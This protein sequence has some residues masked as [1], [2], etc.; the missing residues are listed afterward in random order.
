MKINLWPTQHAHSL[1]C[2][3]VFAFG[4]ALYFGLPLEPSFFILLG[5]NLCVLGLMF[6]KP[7]FFLKLAFFFCLGLT[8]ASARTHLVHTQ[9]LRV[10]LWN[11]TITGQVAQA[12]TT[13]TGQK[14]I[15]KNIHLK[16]AVFVPNTIRL[17]FKE[18][19]PEL[20]A[21]DI[22]SF[23]GHLTPPSAHQ[24]LRF[25]YQG[26]EAQGTISKIVSFHP[27]P[28]PFLDDMRH[29]IMHRLQHHLSPRQAEIAIPLLT[30]EQ[31]VVSPELYALYRKA[32]IAHVL[33]VSG[34]HMAL[35]AG[36]IFFLIRGLLALVPS[37]CILL[38]AK[39]IAAVVALIATGFYLFLS[40]HQVP[41]TRSFLMIALVL[42][43]ILIDRKTVSLYSLLLVG[44]GL[45][46]FHPEWITSVSFQLSFMAVMILV[47]LFEDVTKHIPQIKFVHLLLTAIAANL[48]VTLALSPFV[49]YHFNQLNPYG[50]V[51]NLLT[52]LLF[53]LFVMPLLF[54]SVLLMPF[55]AEGFLLKSVG[56]FLDIITHIAETI[57]RLP[58]SEILISSFSAWGLSIIALGLCC[59]CLVKTKRRLSG[60]GL[61]A[62]G[63]CVGFWLQPKADIIVSDYGRTVLVRAPS[64]EFEVKGKPGNWTAQRWLKKN[65]QETA[66]LLGN[67]SITINGFHVALD[68]SACDGADLAILS[69]KAKACGAKDIFKPARPTTYF[70]SFEDKLSIHSEEYDFHRR[71][72][73]KPSNYKKQSNS[74]ERK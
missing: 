28:A 25:F 33:S 1:W 40:G 26:I 32:G 52:S 38:P 72:W 62:A 67:K 8:L 17:S 36:F 22:L 11:K 4:V 20:H 42:L 53:S 37:L 70:L 51:G 49:A 14:I 60:L 47:G 56:F 34:F 18:Q 45:L 9:F 64:G 39:K 23:Q 63:L 54:L 68:A 31:Q 59:L 10:P 65:G 69:G 46:I 55:H 3:V 12:Y 71:P 5:G 27:A 66:S 43:G 29:A 58:L 74:K 30:G 2:F 19:T 15:L 7:S 41:A 24:A 50:L 48:L 21:G 6:W 44:F 16:D 13:H 73:R 35:L 61:I 57:S